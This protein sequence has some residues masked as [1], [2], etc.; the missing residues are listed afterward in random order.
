MAWTTVATYGSW[1]VRCQ[2]SKDG[3]DGKAGAKSCAAVLELIDNK[4]KRTVMAWIVGP[5]GK[6]AL[7]TV[8]QVPTGVMVSSGLDL[9][10]GAAAAR[11]IAYLICL[12]Q[13][14]TA[15]APMDNAFVKDALAAQ[16]ADVVLY[17]WDGKNLDFGI[18]V[19]GLDKAVAALRK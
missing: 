17:S 16:K 11:H 13:Q 2:N 10:L 9:K 5:D 18:P 12:P 3:K 1:Q 7:Q 6:G 14:C 15:A 19:T 8:F 4:T